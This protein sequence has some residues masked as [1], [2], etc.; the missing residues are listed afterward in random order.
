[1]DGRKP[2][3]SIGLR[4]DEAIAFMRGLGATDAMQFDSG[5]STSFA[6]RVLGEP[7][8]RVINDPTDGVERPVANGVFVYSDAPL[9]AA[10]RLVVRPSTIRAV[11]GATVPL[12]SALTDRSGHAVG[13]ASG[14]WTLTGPQAHLLGDSIVAGP[15]PGSYTLALTR[16]GLVA[17]VPLLILA[18]PSKLEIDPERP[19]P[20]SGASVALHA[21]AHD[22]RGRN[23]GV[24][25]RVVWSTDIGRI[26]S[27]GTYTA[28]ATDAHVSARVG[29]AVSTIVVR[30]GRHHEAFGGFESPF[31]PT[32]K[33]TTVP[34]DGPGSL[35]FDGAKLNLTYDFTDKTRAAYAGAIFTIG[36][37][38]S[39]NCAID[40]DGNGVALR[41]TIL[42]RYGKRDALTLAKAVDWTGTQR[43]EIL[44][45]SNLIPPLAV[46]S[47]YAVG[48]LGNAPVHAAGTLGIHDC[49]LLQP[50]SAP[51]AP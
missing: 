24:V 17:N 20:D 18:N 2:V 23:I 3:E 41:V 51:P 6:V 8:A 7:R 32:W 36:A 33:F 9:E 48:T 21:I 50:G 39:M 4:R 13:S 34:K 45:P 37:P 11:P 10:S 15:R 26:A 46:L 5:G 29:S 40:G 28:A 49:D 22:E 31:V 16:N 14:P 19:N 43:R 12:R 35:A 25:G 27:D 1:V 30:V 38:L 47:F 42:D 44:F